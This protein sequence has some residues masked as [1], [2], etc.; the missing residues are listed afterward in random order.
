MSQPD[1]ADRQYTIENYLTRSGRDFLPLDRRFVQRRVDNNRPAP[2]P[3][4]E[5]VRRGREPALEQFLLAHA[6][7]SSD[8]EGRYDVRL[9]G[10]TWARAIGA[11]FH[12]ETGRVEPAALHLVSRN[13][14]FLEE[15]KLIARER[16]ARRTRI[17]LLADDG[18]GDDYVH[19]AAGRRGQR[20]ED[21]L[22]GYFKLP[23]EYWR[24]KWHEKLEL[25]AKAMLLIGLTL[26]DGFA[27]PYG[28]VPSWYG[29]SAST[30]E[31]GLTQLYDVGL[32]HRER[33]RRADP[34]SPV[35]FADTYYYGLR[36][37]FGPRG[38]LSRTAHAKWVGTAGRTAKTEV[39]K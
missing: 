38:V 15:M 7:A 14:R 33:W 21:G 29:I 18:S 5:F 20:L 39:L 8:V 30:A 34:E 28:Q 3:L 35:G 1:I 26:G 24:A 22:P 16:A 27:L 6:F 10:T 2:G 4:S 23:Y 13:W 25:P 9:P 31:R 37:P 19:P 17:W 32:L 12:P 11:W 36:P